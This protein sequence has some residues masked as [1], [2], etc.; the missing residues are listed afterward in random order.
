MKKSSLIALICGFIA[1]AITVISYLLI[2]DSIFSNTIQWVSLVFLII[3]E[4]ITILKTMLT[5]NIVSKSSIFTSG[6]HIATVLL[7]TSIFVNLFPHNIKAYILINIL[8][9]CIL[10]IAD[11]LIFYFA[12]NIS[13]NNKKLAQ[14][15]GAIEACYIKAQ[16]LSVIYAQSEY[17]NDLIEIAELIKHSDNSELT[18]DEADIINKLEELENQLKNN[19][20]G[21]PALITDIKNA[22]NMRTIKIK[23]IKKGG[24]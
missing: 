6:V 8:I 22:I 12:K 18:N 7:L 11:L 16:R 10:A 13:A 2:F 20:E 15:Q 14:S 23:S 3:A 5:K 9:L 19:N 4:I 1:I 21:I 24:Y 17:K